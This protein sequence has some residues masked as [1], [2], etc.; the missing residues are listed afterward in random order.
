MYLGFVLS[1]EGLKMDPKKIKAIMEWPSQKSV[2]EVR[3][4]HNLASFYRKEFYRNSDIYIAVYI[5]L[6]TCNS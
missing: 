5:T 6:L 4:F 1:V 3:T 2:F